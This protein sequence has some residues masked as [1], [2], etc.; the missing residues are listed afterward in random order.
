[1]R[2]NK[3]RLFRHAMSRVDS[4][5]VRV[6]IETNAKDKSRSKIVKGDRGDR[7]IDVI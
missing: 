3:Q 1:M 7:A 5:A 4:K 6:V 2:N